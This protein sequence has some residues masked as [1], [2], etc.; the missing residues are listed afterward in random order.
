MNELRGEEAIFDA[1]ISLPPSER[2]AFLDQAC[3]HDSALRRSVEALLRACEHSGSLLDD[4][5]LPELGKILSPAS[6]L[7]EQ[8]GDRIGG[9]KLLQQIGEG[10]CGAVYMA[11]QE[12]PVR[13]R[14]ALK[15]IKLGMD[16]KRVVARFEAERQ[17]LAL[18][19]HPNIAR[20]LE[21]G[22]TESGR[23]FFVMELVRGTRITDYCD[24]NKLS[25][26]ERLALFVQVCRAIQHAHQ[27]GIIHRDIKPSNIL[28]T[29][30][31]GVPI[32][33]VIDFGI[34]KATSD[35]RLT[36]KTVFT[37]FEQFVG[38]PAY[39][40][41]EQAEM[42]GLDIDTRS[43]IYA[44]GVLL[45]EL[46]TS[47]TPFDSKDLLAA[48]LDEMRR[49]IREREPMRPSTCLSTMLAGELTA[50]AQHRHTDASRL[51]HLLGGDLDWIVMKCLEKD[52]SRR[53][54]TANG[55]ASDVQRHLHNEPIVARP[56]SAFYR[57]QKL[58]RRNKAAFIT[59]SIGAAG[60]LCAL[61]V[62]FASNVRVTK[63]KNQKDV[64]LKEKG[65][66]L[67]AA[68]TSE[69]QARDQLFL[70]LRSQAQARRYSR[71]TGQRLDSL[72]ALEAAARIRPDEEL[73]DDAI[74]S[75][76][77]PDIR[78]GPIWR[79]MESTSRAITFDSSYERA[80]R[81]EE[82]GMISI[83]TV[84]DD[85]ELQ[86]FGPVSGPCTNGCS[87]FLSP[88]G[89]FLALRDGVFHLHVWR[90][91]DG[92]SLFA[93]EGI[94]A[95][96]AAFSPL[97][98]QLAVVHQNS[99][100]CFDLATGKEIHR[101]RLRSSAY[102]LAFS[103][104]CR[105]LAVGSVNSSSAF[106]YDAADGRAL[107][108]LPLQQCEQ[109]IVAWHPQGRHLA[110]AGSDPRIQIW[111]VEMPRKVATLDGHVQQ[112]T[113]LSFHPD[114]ELLASGG[115]EGILRLWDPA[116][117]RQVIQMPLGVLG[118][119][120]TDGRWLGAGMKDGGRVQLL[121][122]TPTR[123]Y[124][125]LI[126]SA[127]AEETIYYQGSINPDGRLLA[128][129]MGDGV[130][131]WDLSTRA[132]VAFLPIGTVQSVQFRPDGRRLV[133]CGS[134]SGLQEW[135][136]ERDPGSLGTLRLG[137]PHPIGLPWAPTRFSENSQSPLAAVT[138]EQMG[139][140]LVLDTKSGIV[141]GPAMPHPQTCYVALSEDDRWMAS[142]GW[143]SDSVRLWDA[144]SSK[145]VK[146]WVLGRP[147]NVFFTPDSRELIICRGDEFIF[148]DLQTQDVRRRLRPEIGLYP[149]HVAFSPDGKLMALEMA[150]GVVHLKET[151]TAR[152]IAKLEDP[153]G[154]RATWIGFTPSGTQLVVAARYATAI[155]L[156][157]LE[158]IRGRLATMGLDWDWPKFLPSPKSDKPPLAE[159]PIKIQ[160]ITAR[161]H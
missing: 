53:Y 61:V 56:P 88:D 34:A 84:P 24:Q 4:P 13:R 128:L 121:E 113:F 39:M 81:L 152:T 89:A 132:T 5:A 22:A 2:T 41:P 11:E 73:R 35:Q 158:A 116:S 77:L 99:L 147:M 117:G 108:E 28:V 54:E 43:D 86:R 102:S 36:D 80:A 142:A 115:W 146:E 118:R 63:E 154:D 18:M 7:L 124:H 143:H 104:D 48:G 9:Y 44:L 87:L 40:S 64:A 49:T 153:F 103:P 119:F 161:S 51:I 135:A 155:H 19:D 107:A 109:Q 29:L 159:S 131:L 110:I 37:A 114:G 141:V 100:L 3:G 65:L 79:A 71:Q 20:V 6:P 148:V 14:V 76:A 62:L 8:P 27:K 160:V 82:N 68:R 134:E 105:N 74:A 67:E 38:T 30:H 21:A 92:H 94:E 32:P 145:L 101:W 45:Y 138:S 91:A 96:S 16:T 57:F 83:R 72:A 26:S 78:R 75:F 93:P 151:S 55:L 106:I 122:V 47:K 69:R 15:V 46:L 12:A 126:N 123:E 17:A 129:G 23:P 98:W 42:S 120:S 156:W 1:A 90:C 33:K 95:W 25:T 111:D 137:P 85:R 125:T 60:V 136:I 97:G 59:A 70:A 150:P 10:G 52:R 66:A 127:G 140:T 157:D 50:T 139:Q 130:R 112:V 144:Q 133:T 31:D 58:T 149:G